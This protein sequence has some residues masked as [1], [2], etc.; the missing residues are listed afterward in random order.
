MY[1]RQFL[2]LDKCT[3]I[4]YVHIRRT[5]D[6][7]SGIQR[8]STI[9]VTFLEVENYHKQNAYSELFQIN[10]PFNKKQKLPDTIT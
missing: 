10:I 9:F 8:L 7:V 5:C 3:T 2:I 1:L 4:M 6:L